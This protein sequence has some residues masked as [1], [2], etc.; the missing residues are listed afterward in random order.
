MKT[1]NF[2][3]FTLESW[4]LIINLAMKIWT[5]IVLS[6]ALLLHRNLKTSST[7]SNELKFFA[8]RPIWVYSCC[9][10]HALITAEP[11]CF[12]VYCA[13]ANGNVPSEKMSDAKWKLDVKIT[14]LICCKVFSPGTI[15]KIASHKNPAVTATFL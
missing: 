8:R 13:L 2:K 6:T 5:V 12:Q 4:F 11:T 1:I 15:Q 3:S 14:I 7:F 9:Q 10:R